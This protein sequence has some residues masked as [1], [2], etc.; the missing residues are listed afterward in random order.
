MKAMGDVMERG[1]VLMMSLW[2][3][4]SV[5]ML[6]L[7]AVDPPVP[8]ANAP[9]GAIRGPCSI[10]SGKPSELQKDYPG[11]LVAYSNIKFGAIGS[12]FPGGTSPRPEP[13]TDPAGPVAAGPVAHR[14]L[15]GSPVIE[16]RAA[17]QTALLTLRAA[18]KIQLLFVVLLCCRR[19]TACTHSTQIL[20]RSRY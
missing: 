20:A 15:L 18:D 12:T 16:P 11:A 1:M 13:P 8:C 2:D 5:N 9:P 4:T 14:L 3:D 6:W 10:D 7:D 17:L 19:S